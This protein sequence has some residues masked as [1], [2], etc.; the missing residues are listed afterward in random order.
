[1]DFL[2]S[3]FTGKSG[4]RSPALLKANVALC[5]D[6]VRPCGL[7][8]QGAEPFSKAHYDASSVARRLRT[9]KAGMYTKDQNS[10]GGIYDVGTAN[11]LREQ[12]VCVT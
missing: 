11:Q 2:Q 9:N 7:V 8:V 1:V 5:F 3:K 10:A 6:S 12:L 4:L